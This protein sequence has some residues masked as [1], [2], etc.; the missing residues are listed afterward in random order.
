MAA[1]HFGRLRRR[2]DALV[3]RPLHI[4]Q[5]PS[6]TLNAA[7][8]ER[9]PPDRPTICAHRAQMVPGKTLQHAAATV[10]WNLVEEVPNI[11]DNRADLCHSRPPVGPI[12]KPADSRL[13]ANNERLANDEALAGA[14]TTASSVGLARLNGQAFRSVEPHPDRQPWVN[15]PGLHGGR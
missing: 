15:S 12:R 10:C 14:G 7:T 3:S 11:I 9:G 4:R 8:T 2:S 6:I 13:L 5:C 1:M